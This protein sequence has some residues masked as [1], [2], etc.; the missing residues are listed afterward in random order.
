MVHSIE[1]VFD[2]AT[3]EAIR[4]IW[5]E[6]A[7]AGIPS[8]A[9]ASRPHVTLAVAERIDPQVDAL[10][11]PVTR[12]LPLDAA[13][14]APVLFG[15]ANVVFARLIVPTSELLALHAEVHRLCGPHLEPAPMTN[16]LPGQWTAHVT[17]AR[18]VGGHQLGRALR[19]AGRPAQL[20]GRFAGLR[21][22]DGGKKVEHP[23]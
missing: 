10:L 23:L 14:G 16:S 7:V 1:L 11:G 21:R 6:L 18:R 4:G 2:P 17:M 8:Q 12:R 9:P 22:W 19:V 3:E 13:I 15:R 20:D 5:R